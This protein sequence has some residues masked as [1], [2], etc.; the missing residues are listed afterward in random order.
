M[1]KI[2]V[3]SS[4]RNQYYPEVVK[5]LR[6]AGHDVYD[7]RNPPHGGAGFH[8]TDIDPEASHWRFDQ[9]AEGLVHPLAERQFAADLVCLISRP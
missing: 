4:W 2:Y 1:A 5:R 9:Y 7:F 3:A 6:E 8:W